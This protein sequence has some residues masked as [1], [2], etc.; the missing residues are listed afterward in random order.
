MDLSGLGLT[1]LPSSTLKPLHELIRQPLFDASLPPSDDEFGP[2][3][4]DLQLFLNNNGLGML[5]SELFMLENVSVLSLRNNALAE[6]P[7]SIMQLKKLKELNVASNAIKYLPWEMLD[8]LQ[9]RHCRLIVRPNPLLEPIKDF[10]ES[11]PPLLPMQLNEL[12]IKL[13]RCLDPRATIDEVRT[14]CA[15]AGTLDSRTEL[16]LRLRLGHVLCGRHTLSGLNESKG[17]DELIYLASS[18]VQYYDI[19][20]RPTSF[21]PA[22]HDALL[23]TPARLEQC[24]TTATP[25]RVPSLLELSL[26]TIQQHYDLSQIPNGMPSRIQTV[27]EMTRSIARTQV[28]STCDRSYII[29]RAQWFEYWHSGSSAKSELT[30]ESVLPLLRRACSWACAVP[31]EV[32]T[33]RT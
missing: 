7:A 2:L 14:Q 20:G 3:T 24:V 13:Q 15:A 21:V 11:T 4:P 16:E 19:D 30:H 33:F 32:G 31:T 10:A 17:S 29:A 22:K 28:C 25:T 12:D 27:L 9:S 5:P 6:L 18:A 23:T 26:R 8:I 1:H